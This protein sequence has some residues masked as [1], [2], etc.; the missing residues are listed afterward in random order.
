MVNV[1][2]GLDCMATLDD[3]KP[4]HRKLVK[5]C[6]PDKNNETKAISMFQK[7]NTDFRDACKNIQMKATHHVGADFD[8]PTALP[9]VHMAARENSFS[10]TFNILEIMF[11]SFLVELFLWIEGT[12]GCSFFLITQVHV[13]QKSTAQFRLH[14]ICPH[15]AC[16]CKALLTYYG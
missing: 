13:T 11:L 6:H 9:N 8:D 7:I 4:A 10:I 15:R 12:V 3:I 14:S 2:Y 1:R 16:W 5:K